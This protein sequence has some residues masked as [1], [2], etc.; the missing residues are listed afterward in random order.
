MPKIKYKRILLK[1]SGEALLGKRTHGIDPEV[2]DYIAKAIKDLTKIGVEIAVVFGGGNIFRGNAAEQHGMNR[3]AGDYIG[4]LATVMNSLALGSALT[5]IG[6]DNRVQSALDMPKVCE[7]YIR[8]R[9]MRHLDKGRVVIIGA[10]CGNPYFSTDTAAALRACELECDAVFK[11]TKVDGVYNKDP[12]KHN[13]AEKF[14]SLSYLDIL[15]NKYEVMDNTAVTLCM[16]NEMPIIVFE[17]L[18]PGNIERAVLGKKVGTI[19]QN[20]K[21]AR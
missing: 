14:H 20:K 3:T 19:I 13:N 9:A 6:V 21:G 17:L 1:L 2:A 10:G 18:E 4:M 12:K 15:N 11:A 5:K 8:N 16:D 7:P